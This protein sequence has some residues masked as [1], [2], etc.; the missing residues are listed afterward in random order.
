MTGPGKKLLSESGVRYRVCYPRGK[1]LTTWQPRRYQFKER[2]F[3]ATMSNL[4]LMLLFSLLLRMPYH[5]ISYEIPG[6][7]WIVQMV[8]QA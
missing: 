8:N 2:Q 6:T 3:D 4:T 5:S 7:K 1:C